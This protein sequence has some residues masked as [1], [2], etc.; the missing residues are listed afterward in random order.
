MTSEK[1]NGYFITRQTR[2]GRKGFYFA[3]I[4]LSLIA[5]VLFLIRDILIGHPQGRT[6]EEEI[7]QITFIFLV[8][9]F[10]I[11]TTE[12]VC[13]LSFNLFSDLNSKGVITS[14]FM[15][16]IRKIIWSKWIYVLS[17]LFYIITCTSSIGAYLVGLYDFTD[18]ASSFILNIVGAIIYV[19]FFW[20]IFSTTFIILYFP[21]RSHDVILDVF[22]SDN[23]G[24][25]SPIA[26]YLLKISL[27]ITLFSTLSLYWVFSPT[28]GDNPFEIRLLALIIILALPL[29]YFII[30]TIGLNRIMRAK[31]MEVLDKLTN[32]ITT[33]YTKVINNSAEIDSAY[34][35]KIELAELLRQNASSMREWPFSFSGLRNLL[36]SFLLPIALFVFSNAADIQQLFG[37]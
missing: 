27:L 25:L 15:Q 33:S 23:A 1:Q 28:A 30:P 2:F 34:K 14:D 3:M 31:K 12:V 13:Y 4:V 32:L 6:L 7:I 10:L 24:G 19:E 36:T 21:T 9:I 37:F 35:E 29:F 5:L 16:F 26:S 18:M 20:V 8:I 17:G 11:V 22:A